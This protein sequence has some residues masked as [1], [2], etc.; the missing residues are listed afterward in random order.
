MQI[1]ELGSAD[2]NAVTGRLTKIC[3]FRGGFSPRDVVPA[4]MAHIPVPWLA[5]RGDT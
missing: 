4:D 3:H 2:V 5:A 1:N